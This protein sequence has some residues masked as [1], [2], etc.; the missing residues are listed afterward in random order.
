MVADGA[1]HVADDTYARYEGRVYSFDYSTV[2]SRHLPTNFLSY[3]GAI[4]P[5][6]AVPKVRGRLHETPIQSKSID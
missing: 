6:Y 3:R 4:P 2:V 5:F 1:I